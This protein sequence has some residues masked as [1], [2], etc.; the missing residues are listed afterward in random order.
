MRL[1]MEVLVSTM[2]RNDYALLDSMKIDSNAIVI[3]QCDR[4]S[5]E[6]FDYKGHKI[7]WVNTKDRGLSKSRNMAVSYATKDICLICDDD[8]VL[9][10]NYEK[11]IIDSYKKVSKADI[12]VFNI[13]RIGW[14][15]KEK[16]FSSINRVNKRKTYSSVHITFKRKAI[17]KA[18]IRFNPLFG[19]GSKKYLCAEDALFCIACHKKDLKM[20]TYPAIIAD[21]YCE[22]STWFNG[23]NE[24]YFYDTGAFL[25]EAY[26]R[27]KHVVKW[28]YPFRCMK[29]TNLSVKQIIR[30]IDNGITGYQSKKSFEEYAINED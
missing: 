28:Y 16:M 15:E 13:N 2:N 3:N 24:H 19:A 27:L 12:L 5:I 23:Y 22:Q 8:E 26:P 17:S 9:H 14:N 4:N 18:K 20:Y 6:E 29:I 30:N 21:V 10:D 7:K 11:I 1:E 25:A